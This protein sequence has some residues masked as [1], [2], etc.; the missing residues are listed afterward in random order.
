MRGAYRNMADGGSRTA[1]ERDFDQGRP[2]LL[3]AATC[4]RAPSSC[5]GSSPGGLSPLPSRAQWPPGSPD[6]DDLREEGDGLHQ[7]Q[8]RLLLVHSQRLPPPPK[9]QGLIHDGLRLGRAHRHLV[10]GHVTESA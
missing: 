1:T 2:G 6:P 3:P 7:L 8:V 9:S 10:D 4:P 5:H